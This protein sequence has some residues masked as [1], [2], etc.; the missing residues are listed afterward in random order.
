MNKL[1][2]FNLNGDLS[3]TIDKARVFVL[4]DV[5][6]D[7]VEVKSTGIYMLELYSDDFNIGDYVVGTSDNKNKSII[8]VATPTKDTYNHDEIVGRIIG[9]QSKKIAKVLI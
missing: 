8:A 9:R 7:P 4:V 5:D 2:A 6:V 3:D 1:M